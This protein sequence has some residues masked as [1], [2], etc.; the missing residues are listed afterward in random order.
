MIQHM[1]TITHTMG[2]ESV[3]AAVPLSLLGL[4]TPLP[5]PGH[6]VRYSTAQVEHVIAGLLAVADLP[7]NLTLTDAGREAIA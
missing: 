1:T 7:V 5:R 3:P 6:P 2:A 4:L